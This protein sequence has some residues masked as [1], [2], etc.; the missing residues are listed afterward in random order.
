[1]PT[2][3]QIPTAQESLTKAPVNGEQA[4]SE[5]VGKRAFALKYAEDGRPATLS[6]L[7]DERATLTRNERIKVEKPGPQ[8]WKDIVENYA[9][10]G[11]DSISEDDLERFKWVGVYQQRPKDGYFMMR[12]KIAG[13]HVPTAQLRVVARI[14]RLYADSVADITTRQTFQLHWLTIENMPAVM[15]ELETVGLGVKAGLF[16][17]CGDIT[18]NIVS[19]PLTNIESEQLIDPTEF[20][21][22][23]N[24]FFSSAPEYADLPRKFKIGIFG[25]RGGGQCEINDL[26]F[27]G[28]QRT[29]GRVGYGVM[30]GGGLSTE[31][32]LAQD[33]GIFVEPT[34]AMRVMGAIISVYRDC[35]YRK[36]RKHARVKYLVADWGAAKYREVVEG[37][38]EYRLTDAEAQSER[39]SGYQDHYGVHPQLK[40]DLSYIGVPVIGGRVT[41]D[42]WD[43]V[44]DLADQYGS[45]EVRLT[46]MQSFYIPNIA[47]ENTENVV[48]RLKEIG[49]PVHVSPIYSGMV[50]CT[51]IQYCNIAVAETKNRAR[52]VVTWLDANLK[53]NE[54]EHLRVNLNGCPNSCGQH[55]IADIGFQGCQKKVDGVLKEHFDVFVGGQL[56]SDARFNRRIKRID[57]EE[58]PLAV[59]TLTQTYQQ[60]RQ[61]GESFADFCAR[62]SD[63][64]LADIL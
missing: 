59:K 51:G 33:L 60:Q 12:L 15:D 26:S 29:D 53:F 41:S 54:G 2:E 39:V 19:S 44:A 37:V 38:L 27:Y 14:A 55:W 36:N 58:V 8:V 40:E 30:I 43:A 28:V 24:R 61:N 9:K 48:V 3:I 62:L 49:L 64:E 5:R 52:E 42:Q 63:D 22:E 50:A 20:F 6:A 23:A 25:H 57:A 18:R 10:N 45:G 34:E 16:G 1:M 32:H 35:G 31:P 56:G 17:A 47:R 46:V 4:A 7:G 13:G 21:H 11:F